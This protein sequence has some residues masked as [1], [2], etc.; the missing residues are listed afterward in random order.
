MMQ[1]PVATFAEITEFGIPV[2]PEG[3]SH[4]GWDKAPV[5]ELEQLFLKHGTV[6]ITKDGVLLQ[7]TKVR[8]SSKSRE[9]YFAASD[10]SAHAVIKVKPSDIFVTNREEGFS[11]VFLNIL[12]QEFKARP[13]VGAGSLDALSFAV[14]GLL[15][16]AKDKALKSVRMVAVVQGTAV[17]ES[18]EMDADLF[19]R[20]YIPH[21]LAAGSRV[22]PHG[23]LPGVEGLGVHDTQALFPTFDKCLG[24]LGSGS[25]EMSGKE[26]AAYAAV[27]L[28]A[29]LAGTEA[30]ALKAGAAMERKLLVHCPPNLKKLSAL[31]VIG[32]I[33]EARPAVAGRAIRHLYFPPAL[34]VVDAVPTGAKVDLMA[35]EGSAFAEALVTAPKPVPKPQKEKRSGG[36]GESSGRK[37][38]EKRRGGKGGSDKRR[39]PSQSSSE[40]SGYSS[41]DSSSGGGSSSS[42][43][44]D[45]P[46]SKKARRRSHAA[47]KAKHVHYKPT[48]LVYGPYTR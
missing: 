9:I 34:A 37:R 29:E 20:A 11:H 28:D 43:A 2:P 23:G 15:A 36:S 45:R 4:L 3:G 16:A 27:T 21:G 42:S 48:R 24:A 17:G 38:A 47:P 5:E 14:S 39:A 30:G 40:S 46:P 6:V 32:A 10:N 22:R 35:L 18:I 26:L 33:K 7:A 8:G 13:E 44:S 1:F 25:G 19:F 12:G 31:H 41:S